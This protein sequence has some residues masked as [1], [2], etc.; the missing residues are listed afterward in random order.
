MSSS[1]THLGLWGEEGTGRAPRRPLTKTRSQEAVSAFPT[2]L[3]LFGKEGATTVV[4]TVLGY[5]PLLPLY[6]YDSGV[7]F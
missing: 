1:Q 5:F 3:L 7:Y 2:L 6:V 4:P